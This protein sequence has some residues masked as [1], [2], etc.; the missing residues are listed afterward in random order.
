MLDVRSKSF[1]NTYKW[2]KDEN[3]KSLYRFSSF[4][5]DTIKYHQALFEERLLFHNLPVN[6]NDPFECRPAIQWPES[7]KEEDGLRRDLASLLIFHGYE[8]IHAEAKAKDVNLDSN[9]KKQVEDILNQQFQ[10]FRIC[11]FT[12]RKENLL[13]WSHYADSHRG[14]CV[15]YSTSS[16]IIGAAYKVKYGTKFPYLKFPLLNDLRALTVL[17]K[18]LAEGQTIDRF[19]TSMNNDLIKPI[20]NKSIDWK[21]E[22]EYRSI[23]KPDA[24]AQL[25][26]NGECL[27]LEGH[28]IRNVYFG[29]NMPE[30]NR[31]LLIESIKSGPFTPDLW[32]ARMT[33]GMFSLEFEKISI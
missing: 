27:I 6:F 31:D 24:I 8:E 30:E 1:R 14:Y 28:E 2:P 10:A 33:R 16:S 3:I 13:F 32:Q 12:K 4:D 20:L 11:C 18:Q 22:E 9:I 15:D 23:L 19:N 17:A 29:C 7:K 5:P 25:N 26:N 21:Y